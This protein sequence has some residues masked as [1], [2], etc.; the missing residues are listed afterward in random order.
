MTVIKATIVTKKI[1]N[2]SNNDIVNQNE[3]IRMRI[4]TIEIIKMISI[5]IVTIDT[6]N[7]I[8]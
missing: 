3:M 1:Y 5:V 4:K 6:K 2:Y 7:K 8:F